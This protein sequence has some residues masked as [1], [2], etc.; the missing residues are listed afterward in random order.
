[1]LLQ[2]MTLLWWE[3]ELSHCPCMLSI[4]EFNKKGEGNLKFILCC[5]V[6]ETLSILCIGLIELSDRADSFS[7]CKIVAEEIHGYN[8]PWWVEAQFFKRVGGKGESCSE[9]CFLI[10]ISSYKN[11]GQPQSLMSWSLM[12]PIN[13][14]KAVGWTQKPVV[15]R[16]QKG[17]CS[18]DL[19]PYVQVLVESVLFFILL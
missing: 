6:L 1:M 16:L 12:S 7:E 18:F 3:Q 19:V 4:L 2:Q 14:G 9:V 17:W 11:S 5:C 10:E 15:Q 13:F 8:N